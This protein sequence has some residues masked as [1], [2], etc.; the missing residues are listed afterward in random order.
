M[1]RVSCTNIEMST[2][3]RNNKKSNLKM[4]AIGS[5][6]INQVYTLKRVK[7]N[8]FFLQV[9]IKLKVQIYKDKKERYKNK[10]MFAGNISWLCFG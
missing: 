1:T 10:T 4:F 3:L 6:T 7:P 9:S 2:K 5:L 8:L